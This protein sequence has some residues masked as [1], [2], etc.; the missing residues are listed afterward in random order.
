MARFYDFSLLA[1]NTWNIK[2]QKLLVIKIN[3][4]IFKRGLTSHTRKYSNVSKSHHYSNEQ[5]LF[6]YNTHFS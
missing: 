6:F 1:F 5:K 4:L 3:F 2:V